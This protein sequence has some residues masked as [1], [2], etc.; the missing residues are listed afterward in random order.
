MQCEACGATIAQGARFCQACGAT[1]ATVPAACPSCGGVLPPGQRFCGHCG[2]DTAALV[3]NRAPPSG[4]GSEAS[5]AQPRTGKGGSGCGGCLGVT[6]AGVAGFVLLIFL[7]AGLSSLGR[8]SGAPAAALPTR[9]PLPAIAPRATAT[10]TPPSRGRIGETLALKN[11]M[12]TV[13]GVERPGKTVVWSKV[14]NKTDATG[15][16]LIVNITAVN[17]GKENF[18]LNP[19]DFRVVTVDGTV[20]KTATCCFSYAEYKGMQGLSN[21]VPPGVP[22]KAPVIFDVTPGLAGL[23]FEFTQES[24]LRWVL[25]QD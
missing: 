10:P 3:E 8:T 11:W 22:I 18:G 23:T 7:V 1:G 20:Y 12:I 15:E 21:Q 6:A 2:A 25:A 14:G 4:P 5:L 24:G 13:D 16:F 19:W 17:T 9:T